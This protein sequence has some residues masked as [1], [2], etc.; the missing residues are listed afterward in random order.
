MG[1][2]S[3]TK[4]HAFERFVAGRFRLAG[5]PDAA[6]TLH[7]TR[8]GNCGDLI[9][10]KPLAVQC[11]VGAAPSPWRALREAAAAAD[12]GDHAVAILRRD[13]ERAI[14]VMDLDDWMEMASALK[15]GGW[16]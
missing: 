7:E 6:R 9:G 16:W 3:R 15:A 4:G 8:D 13:R 2:K 10:V 5:W 1:R 11:K 14:A 12:P